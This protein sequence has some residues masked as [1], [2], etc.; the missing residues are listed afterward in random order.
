MSGASGCCTLSH[1]AICCGDQSRASLAAT[2]SRSTPLR[3]SLQGLRPPG[4]VPSAPV[5]RGGPIAA[6]SAIAGDL[7]ADRR[8]CALK[9]AG[10]RAHRLADGDPPR[11]LLA[12][13]AP[14]RPPGAPAL[15]A[16]RRRRARAGC[17]GSSRALDRAPGQCR[18]PILRPSSAPT[19]PGA[20]R[21]CTP[22]V[23][24]PPQ[25]PRLAHQDRSVALTG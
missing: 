13:G 4:S 14:K 1:P 7:A 25:P 23:L 17:C 24:V 8:G 19:T 11:D 9:A 5:C 20:P 18:P 16:A 6:P 21:L 15:K 3:Q 10:D 22:V 12:L 2:S